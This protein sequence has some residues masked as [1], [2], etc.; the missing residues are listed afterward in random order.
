M[1]TPLVVFAG[2]PGTGKSTL[3]RSLAHILEAVYLRARRAGDCEIESPIVRASG[4]WMVR[5]SQ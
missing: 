2:L 1:K 5:R 3:A 4:E